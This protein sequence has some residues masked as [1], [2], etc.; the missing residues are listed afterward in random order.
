MLTR[1]VRVAQR[2]SA[3][4]IAV[5][6]NAALAAAEGLTVQRAAGKTQTRKTKGQKAKIDVIPNRAERPART[7]P[8]P[9]EGNL[10]SHHSITAALPLRRKLRLGRSKN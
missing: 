9:A 10:L 1:P 5:V 4:V 6:L 2:F 8:E 7:C 3:A